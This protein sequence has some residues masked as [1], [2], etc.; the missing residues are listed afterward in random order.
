MENILPQVTYEDRLAELQSERIALE[1]KTEFDSYETYAHEFLE[2][3]TRYLE[4]GALSGYSICMKKYQ[5]YI[6]RSQ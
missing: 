5:Y 3:A 6:A 1:Q 4:I 2:L